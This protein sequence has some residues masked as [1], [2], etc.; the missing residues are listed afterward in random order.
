MATFNCSE[1]DILQKY[2]DSVHDNRNDLINCLRTGSWKVPLISAG[3]LTEGEWATIEEKSGSGRC[4]RTDR[5]TAILD[6]IIK[7]DSFSCYSSFSRVVVDKNRPIGTQCFPFI[8]EL[9]EAGLH[10][11]LV[12]QEQVTKSTKTVNA[13]IILWLLSS[14]NESDK[15]MKEMKL[16]SSSTTDRFDYHC[17]VCLI[18]T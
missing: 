12:A 1:Q 15:V 18:C 17:Q 7:K 6:L 10:R 8:K 3:C 9:E 4:K 13:V 5:A 2:R 16:K 11:P 14:E